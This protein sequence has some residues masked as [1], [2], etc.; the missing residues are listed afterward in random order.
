MAYKSLSE[1]Q[2]EVGA[3]SK[4]NFGDQDPINPLLGV[5]EEVGELCHAVLKSRQRIRLMD[6]EDEKDAIG[7]VLIYLLDYCHRR[8]FAAIS[9]LNETWGKVSKRDWKK[10]PINGEVKSESGKV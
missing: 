5:V 1:I 3:W 2:G 10:N 9:I 6:I 7:D 8:N 4:Q